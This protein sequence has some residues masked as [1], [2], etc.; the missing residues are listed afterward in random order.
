MD[1]TKMM[2]S[3]FMA[4]VSTVR[5][6]NRTEWM[7]GRE[8]RMNE[9]LAAIGDVDRVSFNGEGFAVKRQP[10]KTTIKQPKNNV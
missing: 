9:C 6:C 3:E 4:Y 8:T 10:K 5:R 7:E 1:K 2:F